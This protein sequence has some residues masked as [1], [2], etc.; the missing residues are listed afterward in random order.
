MKTFKFSLPAAII[1]CAALIIPRTVTAQPTIREVYNDITENTNW[2]EAAKLTRAGGNPGDNFGYSVGISGSY[3]IV[4]V[5]GD[6]DKGNNTGSAYLYERVCPQ[7]DI[8]E[9]CIVTFIDFGIM[10][11]EWLQ[12]N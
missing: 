3:V 5:P 10:A 4:G 6:D 7:G 9:D 1:I 8:S 2:T 12:S 11:G